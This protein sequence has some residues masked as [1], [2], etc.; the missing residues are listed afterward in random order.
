M[1]VNRKLF[2]LWLGATAICVA[3]VTY[4]NCGVGT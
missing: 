4:I 3:L 2:L 1:V